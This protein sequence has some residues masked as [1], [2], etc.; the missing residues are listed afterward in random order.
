MWLTP[1][2]S[3]AWETEYDVDTRAKLFREAQGGRIV[4]HGCDMHITSAAN[5]C[6]N[7]LH[8]RLSADRIAMTASVPPISRVKELTMGPSQLWKG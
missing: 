3:G 5:L 6:I 2:D 1:R 7:G 8:V 4:Y